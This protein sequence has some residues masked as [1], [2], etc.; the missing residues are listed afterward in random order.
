M[1]V[2]S[3]EIGVMMVF[4]QQRSPCVFCHF[5]AQSIKEWV[6]T[7]GVLLVMLAS[8]RQ[9]IKTKGTSK[10]N[11]DTSSSNNVQ[12]T[13]HVRFCASALF[14]PVC[15]CV[16]VSFFSLTLLALVCTG[17]FFYERTGRFAGACVYVVAISIRR[18]T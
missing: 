11:I 18:G 10:S 15:M 5:R 2:F 12:F 7:I 6:W 1:F 8:R 13:A 4:R 16:G 9:Q 14:A 3:S 17:L